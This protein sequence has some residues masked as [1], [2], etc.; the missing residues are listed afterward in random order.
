MAISLFSI[1][2]FTA[3]TNGESVIKI[4]E[5]THSVFYAPL[6]LADSLGYFKDEK[7]KIELTN[8]GGADAS[9][10]ALLS[11][12]ADVAFCGP[13]AGIYVILGGSSD[14]P[15]VF[16]QLTKRDG[17]FLVG[18]VQDDD[19]SWSKLA[20]KEILA[21]R[22]GGVP[23]MTFEYTLKTLGVSATLNYDVAFNMMTSAFESGVA[24]YCTMFEPTA[25]DYQSAGKGYIVASVG[26][27]SGEIPYTCFMAKQSYI[28]KNGDK[29][30]A[31]L[32]AVT[33]AIKYIDEHDANDVAQKIA[34]F[35]DGTSVSSLATSIQNYK[36]IDAWVKNM[37][38]QESAFNRLQDVMQNAG[39]LE[40][41]INFADLVLTDRANQIY[42]EIY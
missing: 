2:P 40:R 21:G 36:T 31:L 37:A 24:D 42:N 32:R 15:K 5:V 1:L 34:Y 8:G 29:I 11:G 35:F 16:G 20:G 4:N 19:F 27:E 10:A 3:C 17:S 12:S 26:Q 25:S 41:R 38:M 30:D 13:E 18:R 14:A 9:M 28:D 22:R 6:Y 7:V 23:A 33:K 39:E